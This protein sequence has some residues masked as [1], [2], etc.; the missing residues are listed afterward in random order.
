MNRAKIAVAS[1]EELI[2]SGSTNYSLALTTPTI[3][4]SSLVTVPWSS[5]QGVEYLD[6]YYA[7][8]HMSDAEVKTTEQ[9]IIELIVNMASPFNITERPSFRR[10]V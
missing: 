6:M 10:F 8:Y 4:A 3:S 9:M 1:M 5:S 7:Q 2:A